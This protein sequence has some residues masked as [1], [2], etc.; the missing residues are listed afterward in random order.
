VAG[1][2][3]DPSPTLATDFYGSSLQVCEASIC[4]TEELGGNDNF[5]D[6]GRIFVLYVTALLFGADI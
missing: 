6:V 2:G 4:S 5:G 3:L 1:D